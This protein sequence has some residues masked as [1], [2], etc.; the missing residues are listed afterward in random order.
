MKSVRITV[1]GF[2][3]GCKQSKDHHPTGD[4][5]SE[6]Q[7]FLNCWWRGRVQ[8]I[9]QVVT[10]NL[11]IKLTPSTQFAGLHPPPLTGELINCWTVKK[12][13]Q[14]ESSNENSYFFLTD[15]PPLPEYTHKGS[16][17]LSD[18]TDNTRRGIELS[19]SRFYRCEIQ[20]GITS[21]HFL[22]QRPARRPYRVHQERTPRTL[23]YLRLMETQLVTPRI[24]TSPCRGIPFVYPCGVRFHRFGSLAILPAIRAIYGSK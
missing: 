20:T 23:Y 24:M 2:G 17:T 9:S 19:G 4:P 13:N 12:S 18:N 15:S 6:H 3:A 10:R 14:K 1:G 21:G 11:Q 7:R 8:Q 22:H 5:R 16:R